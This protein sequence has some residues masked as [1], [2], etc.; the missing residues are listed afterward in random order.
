MEQNCAAERPPAEPLRTFDQAASFLNLPVWKLR[1]AANAG[2]FPTYK[3]ANSRRLV[4]LSEV[5]AA[6]NATREGGDR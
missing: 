1:R 2:I 5:V 4:R 3:L 6:I